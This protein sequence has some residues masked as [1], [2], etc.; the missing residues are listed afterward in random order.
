MAIIKNGA[1]S[2]QL[3]IDPISKAA[4]VTMYD[5]AGRE[6]SSQKL[7]TF[8][9]SGSFTPVATPTDIVTII[10]SASKTV[11]VLSVTLGTVNTAAGSQIL[12]LIKRS[13]ADT[14]GTPVTATNV[15]FDSADTATA[16]VQHYTANPAALGTTVGTINTVKVSSPV[17]T[18]ATFAGIVFRTDVELLPIATLTGL[19]KPV[20]LRGVAQQLA[21]NFGGAA[22]V[23][24]QIHTYTVVWTE[25]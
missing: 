8:A 10:G 14:G 1:S 20:T 18:P 7:T 21:V 11:R 12:F 22:L 2:D 3:T 16:V 19:P 15:P 24:G 5:S 6:V 23:A 4:R 25:E 13:T 17:A 9:A